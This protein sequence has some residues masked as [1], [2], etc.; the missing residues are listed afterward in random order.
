MDH[1]F[2]VL[3]PGTYIIGYKI[4]DTNNIPDGAHSVEVTFSDSA[5]NISKLS[6]SI[7]LD[8]TPDPVS[9]YDPYEDKI[10]ID[11]YLW[12]KTTAPDN[13]LMVV[14]DFMLIDTVRITDTDT[15]GGD[16]WET[17][18]IV[19]TLTAGTYLVRAKGYHEFGD[20]I[21]VDTIEIRTG[22]NVTAPPPSVGKIVNIPA[23]RSVNGSTEV[24]QSE[25]IIQD[26]VAGTFSNIYVS[27]ELDKRIS[28]GAECETIME[29]VHLR[30]GPNTI[31]VSGIDVMDRVVTDTL[32]VTYVEPIVTQQVG[33]AGGT[34]EAEDGVKLDIPLYALNQNTRFSITL[35]PAGSLQEIKPLNPG[36]IPIN[37]AREFRPDGIIFNQPV[38]LTLAYDTSNLIDENGN[39]ID[40][41]TLNIFSYDG[42][43]WIME[44]TEDRD[45]GNR[46]IT[47]R[48][49]HFTI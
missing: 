18:F 46:T 6:T 17:K 13:T 32:V 21:G 41:N 40:P 25:I 42:T 48:V 15:F 2:G 38:L 33:P 26:T 11:T 8:N 31:V 23:Y 27:T 1:P 4:I 29:W 16:G 24:Y 43:E 34:V 45:F 30:R 5:G 9:I 39:Y 37:V 20:L 12:A 7:V 28:V 10:I 36:L 47:A 35:F 44:E 14:F 49:N 19:G 3:E 22:S